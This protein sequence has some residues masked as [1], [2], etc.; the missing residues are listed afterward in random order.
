[1]GHILE[2][3]APQ[4]WTCQLYVLAS[5]GESQRAYSVKWHL[6]NVEVP[7]ARDESAFQG[8]FHFFKGVHIARVENADVS[9]AHNCNE[10]ETV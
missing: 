2:P 7:A 9:L 4:R 5:S 3:I 8:C 6:T 10:S 1:M